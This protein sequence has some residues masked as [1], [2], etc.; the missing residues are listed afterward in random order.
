M[1]LR[2]KKT[3]AHDE[4][5]LVWI[6]QGLYYVITGIWSLVGV[7][8]FQEVTG[9]KVDI[10]LL[11]TV[12]VLVTIIGGVLISAGLRRERTPE[13]TALSIGSAAAL[14]GV[15]TWYPLRGRISKV[16]LLDTVAEITLIGL[17]FA[18]RRGVQK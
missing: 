11:K 18:L 13:V 9:P 3:P 8:S 17:W 15:S 1:R 6:V 10:W 2:R 14:A 4:A 16:Y 12:G 7:R 5:S